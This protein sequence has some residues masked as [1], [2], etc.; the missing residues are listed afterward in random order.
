MCDVEKESKETKF[1]TE[2]T[3]KRREPQRRLTLRFAGSAQNFFSVVLFAAQ[4]SPCETLHAEFVRQHQRR[5]AADRTA[6]RVSRHRPRQSPPPAASAA[7]THA[8][9]RQRGIQFPF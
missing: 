5:V 4:R 9:P 7:E 2:I 3:E 6:A 1:R 8:A